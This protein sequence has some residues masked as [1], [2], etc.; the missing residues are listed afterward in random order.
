MKT[1]RKFL[2]MLDLRVRQH[3]AGLVPTTTYRLGRL[4][5]IESLAAD[6]AEFKATEKNAETFLS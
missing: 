6:H 2:Q 3:R 1:S 5:T 4:H